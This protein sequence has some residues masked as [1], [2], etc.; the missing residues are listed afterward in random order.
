M[1][2]VA[3]PTGLELPWPPEPRPT[4]RGAVRWDILFD[5]LHSQLEAAERDL[6]DAEV[7]DLLEAERATTLLVDRLRAAAGS[8]VRV[9]AEGAGTIEG[10]V[11]DAGAGWI[12]VADG[13][14]QW[15][16]AA[17]AVRTVAV[18]AFAAPPAGAVASRLGLGH[19]LRALARAGDVVQVQLRDAQVL[20]GWLVRVGVD[21][22]DLRSDAP[23]THLPVLTIPFTA[24]A[25]VRTG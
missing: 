14:R 19:T 5:D 12:L 8:V 25:A 2:A 23:A 16:I 21:H 15:L 7:G 20:R 11:R 17:A 4:Y 22:V 9:S 13:A 1:G 3:Q 24:L 6:V 18:P 10:L